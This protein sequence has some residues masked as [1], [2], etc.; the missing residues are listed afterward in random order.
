VV[1]SNVPIAIGAEEF[2]RWLTPLQTYDLLSKQWSYQTICSTL[3]RLLAHSEVLAR[4]RVLKVR[5]PQ[6]DEQNRTVRCALVID[7]LWEDA[8]PSD[9]DDFWENGLIDFELNGTEYTCIDVRFE[10]DAIVALIKQ[11]VSTKA[12]ESAS[13]PSQTAELP[14]PKNLRGAHRKDWWDHLW[15]EMIRRIRAGTLKPK[16]KAELQEILEACVDEIGGNY[17]DSTLKPM[18]SNLFEYLEEIRGK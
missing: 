16:N 9:G 18:A 14:R 11:P 1:D 7:Y 17:G 8:P 12:P 3:R 6:D 5:P 13:P 15:I 4:A 2:S 10:P